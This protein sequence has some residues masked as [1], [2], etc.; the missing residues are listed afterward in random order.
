MAQRPERSKAPRFKG[1]KPASRNSSNAKKENRSTN[2]AAEVLLR[3]HLWAK[4]LRYRLHAAD[5]PGRPDI[6]FRQYRVA[7]FVDGD[8]WHG[9]NWPAR[10]AK[11]ARGH[12]QQYWV[13]KIQYNIDRDHRN[14]T[15]LRE[16]GWRV[17]RL[18]E[19]DIKNSLGAEAAKV[20]CVLSKA[21]RE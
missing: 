13:A 5:L 1:C 14:N 12:N 15:L 10:R 18:W 6:V 7:V 17:V 11:L 20:I 16:K 2:S 3:Q 4:G 9:R 21:N 19:S 8:F